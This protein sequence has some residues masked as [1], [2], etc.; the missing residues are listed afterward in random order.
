MSKTEEN[1]IEITPSAV[2]K[3]AELIA[4]RKHGPMA[5]RVIL[6]GRLPGGGFKSEFQLVAIEDKQEEDIMQD[7]GVFP[8]FLDPATAE[9]IKGAKVDFDENKYS[10][11]FHILYPEQI[12]DNPQAVRKDWEDPIAIAVQAAIDKEVNPVLANHGGWV[13]LLDVKADSA[14]IE[15]GG[16]CQGCGLS[17]A[18]LKQGIQKIIQ[19]NVPEILKVLDVTDHAEGKNPYYSGDW[20]GGESAMGG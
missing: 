16:G 14:F 9:S 7:M 8:V 12:A 6:H 3:I 13:S 10:A 15:M 17:E 2:D 4:E 5:V 19:T 18:T 20:Q 11:G 1:H